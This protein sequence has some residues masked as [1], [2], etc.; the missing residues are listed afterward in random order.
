MFKILCMSCSKQAAKSLHHWLLN[1]LR[2]ST[3]SEFASKNLGYYGGCSA[4][5]QNMFFY[6]IHTELLL[7]KNKR[8]N[9][10][11][12]QCYVFLSIVSSFDLVFSCNTFL[13]TAMPLIILIELISNYWGSETMVGFVC[14]FHLIDEFIYFQSYV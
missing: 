12:E 3:C 4:R 11:V 10:E 2:F 14:H 7:K 13:I 6:L 9:F 5:L 8:C 1:A